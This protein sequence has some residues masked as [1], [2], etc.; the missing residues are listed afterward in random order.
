MVSAF[1]FRSTWPTMAE[2]KLLLVQLLQVRLTLSGMARPSMFEPV[3]MSCWLGVSPTPLTTVPFSVRPDSLLI[4]LPA[5]CRSSTLVAMTTPLA[6]CQG[7]RPIRSRALTVAPGLEALVLELIYACQV[8]PPAPTA[9]ASFWQWASAPASPP[10]SPPL[11]GPS[12]VTKKVMLAASCAQAVPP[13]T[14]ARSAADANMDE[15]MVVF[16]SV[17]P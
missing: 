9:A 16:I 5:L 15:R 13:D 1:P 6:F 3:S 14:R 12:L 10:K 11:P 7:P 17:L 8:L 2:P 4:L